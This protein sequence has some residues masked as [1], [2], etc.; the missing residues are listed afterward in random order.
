M[1]STPRDHFYSQLLDLLPLFRCHTNTIWPSSFVTYPLSLAISQFPIIFTQTLHSS[2]SLC[3][4]SQPLPSPPKSKTQELI[5]LSFNARRL[6]PKLDELR[7]IVALHNPDLVCICETWFTPEIS[8]SDPITPFSAMTVYAPSVVVSLFTLN[9][10]SIHPSLL[11]H[12]PIWNSLLSPFHPTIRNT[13]LLVSIVL[14]LSTAICNLSSIFSPHYLLTRTF[15]CLETSISTPSPH[16]P[17]LF[18]T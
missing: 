5:I 7:L 15:F 14:L 13:V 8:N 2:L 18:K 10:H 6:F 17:H 12:F 1:Y 3:P 4:R 11:S 9:P 16:V